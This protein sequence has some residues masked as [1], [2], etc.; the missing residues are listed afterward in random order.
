MTP[1]QIISQAEETAK[2]WLEMSDR[3][4]QFMIGYLAS[5]ISIL[6]DEVEFYKRRLTNVYK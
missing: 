6:Q 1:N 3:P 5:K 4:D 2:E